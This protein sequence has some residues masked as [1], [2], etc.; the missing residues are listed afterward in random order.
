M[1]LANLAYEII[2]DAIEFQSGFNKEGFI[3]GDFDEDRNFSLQISFAFNYINLAIARLITNRKTLLKVVQKSADSAGY[4]DFDKGEVTAVVSDLSPKYNRVFFRPFSDG[5]AVEGGYA[6]KSVYVEYRPFVPNFSIDSIRH[7]TL[8]EDNRV[9]YEELVVKLDDY[10]ITDEMCAYIKEYAKGGLI[11]YISPELSQ[12]HTQMAENY[13]AGL[14]T[15][16][17]N[18]PQRQIRDELCGGGA[19]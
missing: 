3:R 5:I 4:F 15:R 1:K 14:K 18:F 7:Q 16:Y 2:R 17:T 8:D 9:T 19:L 6:S 11:E 12:K 10:G 13:F